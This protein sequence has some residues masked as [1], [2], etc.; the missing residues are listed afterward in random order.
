MKRDEDEPG[1]N[2]SEN[3]EKIGRLA[4]VGFAL[5]LATASGIL[6]DW[7]TMPL[8]WMLGP[9]L[10]CTLAAIL[11]LPV[12]SPARVRSYVVVVIG[13][14]LGSGFTPDFFNQIGVWALSFS[15]LAV[16][17]AVTA[18]IIIPYYR[19]V[20]GFDGPTS[21]FAGM[22]G[23]LSEMM[24]IGKEMGGDERAIALAHGCRI[25]IV[26]ALVAVWF[27]LIQ[28]I[29]LSDR[30][31]FGTPF[32]DIPAMELIVLLTA[33]VVGYFLGRMLR[34]PAPAL[35]GPMLVSAAAHLS[36]ATTSLPPRELVIVAQVFL[37][38][39][40]GCRF[41]GTEPRA[42]LRA[43]RLS[44]GATILMLCVTFAF[45]VLLHGLFRQSLEQVILAYSPGGLAEMSLVA[46]AMDADIAYVASHHLLRI[47]MIIFLAPLVFRFL[48]GKKGSGRA[49][50]Q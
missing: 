8:P 10:A 2:C 39:I 11:R 31:Q 26:V 15:F 27:R 3:S 12:A 17:L 14:M 7:A 22:P 36:G 49:T 18:A 21:Y 9:M 38:T 13:V 43:I 35:L 30:S 19:Y 4:R 16:Y 40:I 41:L 47:S 6:F 25:V 1:Q 33:G 28:D 32:A 37:G 50:L 42:I 24:I 48:P 23:G 44:I 45:A 46:L 20:A 29:N 34:L 5:A